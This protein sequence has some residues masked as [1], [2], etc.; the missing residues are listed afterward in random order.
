[1]NFPFDLCMHECLCDMAWKLSENAT[2]TLQEKK[3]RGK[4]IPFIRFELICFYWRSSFKTSKYLIRNDTLSLCL[5]H[6]QTHIWE[7]SANASDQRNV[8]CFIFL[9]ERLLAASSKWA[10]K[11][12]KQNLSLGKSY[13]SCPL[14]LR[15]THYPGIRFSALV[16]KL[17]TF[18]K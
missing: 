13:V 2:Q 10:I 12:A 14:F 15:I 16:I 3:F 4:K 9:W 1:M 5:F 17:V 11:H 8:M 6:W 7:R 18:W